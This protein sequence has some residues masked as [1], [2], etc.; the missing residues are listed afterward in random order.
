MGVPSARQQA[1]PSSVPSAAKATAFIPPATPRDGHH[2]VAARGDRVANRRRD[3]LLHLELLALAPDPRRL[4]GFLQRH[5]VIDQVD[6][7]LEHGGEDAHAAGQAERPRGLAVAQH[8]RRRHAA[9]HALA[10]RD[11]GGRARVRVE[12]RHGV[13]E[14]HAG[15]GHRG[16]RPEQVVD[17]LG[18]RDH[19]AVRVRGRHVRGVRRSRPRRRPPCRIAPYSPARSG[20]I[21]ARRRPRAPSRAGARPGCPRRPGRRCRRCG[22]RSRS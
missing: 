20:R 16:L 12:E 5:A 11:G 10:G 3:I 6:H 15:A 2:L 13:V 7:R 14:Q 9:G 22:P 18:H 19:I 21:C 1:A 8:D 17:G 4:H